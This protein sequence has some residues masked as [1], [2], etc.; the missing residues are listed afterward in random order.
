MNALD[1][2]YID[3]HPRRIAWRNGNATCPECRRMGCRGQCSCPCRGCKDT[4][5]ESYDFGDCDLVREMRRRIELGKTPEGIEQMRQEYR[6]QLS[7]AAENRVSWG[8][9]VAQVERA[10]CPHE[11]AAFARKPLPSPVLEQARNWWLTGRGGKPVL[12]LSGGTGT[13]K[14]VTA[15]HLAAKFAE[16][17]KWWVGAPTG[18]TRAALMWMQADEV[19][20]LALLSE[21]DREFCEKAET[22]EMLVLD[23]LSVRGHKSGLEAV[24]RIISRRVDAGRCTI[25][26]TNAAKSETLAEGLGSHVADRLKKSKVIKTGDESRRK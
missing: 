23:E 11:T 19:A 8:E 9:C 5:L 15:A 18:A 24:A 7:G 2:F 10:G 12:T 17:R 26:T 21:R 22:C 14:S 3:G 20:S 13:M 25:I 4:P 16:A 6:S 1:E